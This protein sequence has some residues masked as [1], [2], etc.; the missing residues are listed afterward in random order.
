MRRDD[1]GYV[2]MMIKYFAPR[3][4]NEVLPKKTLF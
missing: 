4:Q 3:H 1:A 2:W